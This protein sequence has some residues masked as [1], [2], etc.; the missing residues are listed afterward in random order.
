MWWKVYFG[1]IVFIVTLGIF[2][3]LQF[4]PLAPIDFVNLIAELLLITALFLYVFK[5]SLFSSKFWRIYFWIFM[6]LITISLVEIF[7]LPK[8]YLENIF[9]FLKSNLSIENHDTIIGILLYLPAYYALY[10]LG[11]MKE[12]L[13]SSKK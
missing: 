12:S 13:K 6:T 2:G 11:K 4:A 1:F 10:Q 9:P 8:G 3:L 7:F 5:K